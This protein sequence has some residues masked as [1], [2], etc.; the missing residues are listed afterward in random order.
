MEHFIVSARKYRPTK[1]SEVVGQGH[2]SQTLKNALKM[3]HVAHAFLFCGPRGV[4]KT[5]CARILAK[6]LNC[7]NKSPEYEACNTCSSCQA[8]NDN[9]SFNILELDAASNNGVEH[10]RALIEQVRFQPQRG[11]Y[12][13]FII[14]EVHMLSQAAFNAFLKTLEEPPPHAIFILATTEKHKIIPTILSRCQI[15]DFRRIQTQDIAEHLGHI[16]EKENIKADTDAL[17]IIAQKADG[18]LRDALSIFDRIVSYSGKSIHYQ[19]VLQNLNILDYD[20]YF[21]VVEAILSED[22]ATLFLILDEILTKGFEPDTFMGGLAEHVRNLLICKSPQTLKLLEAGDQLKQRY[23]EQASISPDSILITLLHLIN[24]FDIHFKT[25]KNKRL[26]TEIALVKMC[27]IQ[28]AMELNEEGALDTDTTFKKKEDSIVTEKKVEYIPENKKVINPPIAQPP[29]SDKEQIELPKEEALSIE[30]SAPL[31]T[32]T[33]PIVENPG[34]K[35][36]GMNVQS[37]YASIRKEVSDIVP[38]NPLEFEEVKSAWQ[39]LFPKNP[40]RLTI[41]MEQA[42]LDLREGILTI[43]VGSLLNKGILEEESHIVDSLK[44]KLQRPNLVVYYEI[45]ASLKK[46]EEDTSINKPLTISDKYKLLI[47]KNPVLDQLQKRLG[48]FPED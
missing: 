36:S 27:Y 16:C 15:Y 18:G 11:T 3:D 43:K 22:V 45:D 44:Q 13:V 10:I 21:K 8:F 30:K 1:F 25:A 48:L 34:L 12:K 17:H 31:P 35:I 5:T 19:D 26:H 14:D 4:G 23:F 32:P 46:V 40:N 24:E 47:E 20:F 42:V 7:E 2:I 38:E 29:S 9:A 41:A 33:P 37:L 28:K 39:T 6:I